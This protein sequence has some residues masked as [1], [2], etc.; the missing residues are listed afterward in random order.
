M[1]NGEHFTNRFLIALCVS[2]VLGLV[3]LTL[4]SHDTGIVGGN[5]VRPLTFVGFLPPHREVCQTLPESSRR[6]SVALLTLGLAGAPPQALSVRLEGSTA[7][8]TLTTYADGVVA[9]PLTSDSNA[10][11]ASKA[12]ITNRGTIDVQVAGESVA[13]AT[14][15]T[16]VQPFAMSIT[17]IAPRN[18]WQQ[19]LPYI[20]NSIGAADS[21][22]G[23]PATGL[24]ICALLLITSVLVFSAA[25]R[26]G[27]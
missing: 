20:L 19:N 8:S 25:W 7:V 26:W 9:F 14:I 13:G 15:G 1:T 16:V 18:R 21:G 22:I 24:A 6:P 5:G 11:T 10:V 4:R 2:A 3:T 17:L 23:E 12:C 27:R